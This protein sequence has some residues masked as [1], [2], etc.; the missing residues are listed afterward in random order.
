MNRKFP[1][2]YL[3]YLQDLS[4]PISRQTWKFYIIIIIRKFV[5]NINRIIYI[6]KQIVFLP[7][8]IDHWSID[9]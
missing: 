3:F 7:L 2:M 8:E 1:N 9:Q 4:N 5:I 6:Y